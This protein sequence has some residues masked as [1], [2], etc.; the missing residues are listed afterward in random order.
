[1]GCLLAHRWIA[2]ALVGC[3]GVAAIGIGGCER[4][5][6]GQSPDATAT[7]AND[8]ND[9]RPPPIEDATPATDAS[10][11]TATTTPL[12]LSYF[13]LVVDAPRGWT[14]KS[15]VNGEIVFLEGPTPSG[16]D[17]Q[18][19]LSHRGRV[20]AD[21][22]LIRQNATTREATA[23]SESLKLSEAR[24]SGPLTI[25]EQQSLGKEKVSLTDAHGNALPDTV[26]YKWTV[27]VFVPRETDFENFELNFVGLTAD[28][29]RK[30]GDFLRRIITSIKPIEE[31][32]PP[33][34]NLDGGRRH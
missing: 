12:R 30:E 34:P 6:S 7:A 25:L 4:S 22:L 16:D 2:T 1:M 24:M 21:Q 17:V 26:N 3:A 11:N 9:P 18:I 10:A 20:S 5:P 15:F 23:Q 14:I 33:K 8:P 32:P 27:H 19:Q 29:F 13:P 31:A 28:Q